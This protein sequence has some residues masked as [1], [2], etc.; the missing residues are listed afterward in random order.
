[1]GLSNEEL[2]R[3]GKAAFKAN[4]WP[5]VVVTLI[6]AV[7]TSLGTASAGSFQMVNGELVRTSPSP[8]VN[9]IHFLINLLVTSVIGV[10][11]CRFYLNNRD[12][13]AQFSDLLCGFKEGFANI[14]MVRFIVNIKIVLWSLLLIVPGIIKSFS[15]AMVPYIL[16]DDPTLDQKTAQQRSAEM[17]QGNK[18]RLF[19]LDL[20]FIGWFLLG[21][22]TLGIG[23]ILW[24]APYHE[25]TIAEWYAELSGKNAGQSYLETD[26]SSYYM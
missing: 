18:M 6:V 25:A 7:F 9:L 24:T 1:M 4:F 10:G 13:Q 16:S 20:S 14:V 8:M 22:L 15:W 21:I 5:C 3:R 26:T 17:M 11:S 23:L 12:K 2:K 19:M